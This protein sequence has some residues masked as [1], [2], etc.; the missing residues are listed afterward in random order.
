M[1][2][3]V[4]LP[5]DFCWPASW[6]P[7]TNSEASREVICP[8]P[9]VEDPRGF[10]FE[11]ELQHELCPGHP[12]YRVECLAVARNGAHHDEFIFATA[13]PNYPLAF[14]HLTWAVETTPKFPHTVGYP[15]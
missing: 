7:L 12:L 11:A 10:T 1:P 2:V 15:N 13:N 6:R 3:F 5:D 14:V 8:Q 4:N 9:Y